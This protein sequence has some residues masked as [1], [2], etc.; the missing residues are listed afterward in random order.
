M[1]KRGARKGE[2]G[3]RAHRPT[4]KQREIAKLSAGCGLPK[5]LIASLVGVSE[6]TLNKH[7][8]GDMTL[9]KA[10]IG[11][12]LAARLVSLAGAGDFRALKLYLETQMGWMS[13]GQRQAREQPK[14][15]EGRGVMVAPSAMTAEEWIAAARAANASKEKPG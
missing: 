2:K 14:A 4:K 6:D 3:Q 13:E 8:A 10:E 7:Y 5:Y 15:N 9:G 1:A 12:R 11:Q